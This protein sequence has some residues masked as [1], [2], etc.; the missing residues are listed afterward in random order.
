MAAHDAESAPWSH[1]APA[2]VLLGA[3][4]A[5]VVVDRYWPQTYYRWFLLAGAMLAVHYVSEQR[6]A[7]ARFFRRWRADIAVK[8]RWPAGL[9]RPGWA[10]LAAVSALSGAWHHRTWHMTATDDLARLAASSRGP[11]PVLVAGLADSGVSTVRAEPFPGQ[12]SATAT[13]PLRKRF[14]M[15]VGWLSR[16]GRWLR[17]SGTVW[18]HVKGD[19]PAVRPGDEMFVWGNLTPYRSAMNPGEFDFQ[20]LHRTFGRY[21]Y[22][23]VPVA[24]CLRV[25]PR[26]ISWRSWLRRLQT[27]WEGVLR[28]EL[29]GEA[30]PLAAA[31]LLGLRDG[32]SGR[33]RDDFLMT[34]TSHVLAIS[35]LHVG[36]LAAPWLYAARARLLHGRGALASVIIIVAVY[37]ALAEGRAPVVRASVLVQVLCC[38]WL[39]RRRSSLTNSLGLAGL[40]VLAVRPAELFGAGTQLSFLAVATLGRFHGR[41]RSRDVDPLEQLV[42]RT[43]PWWQ[44]A[45]A[46]Q[47]ERITQLLRASLAVWLVTAPLTIQAFHILSPLAI[48]LNLLLFPPL[49]VALQSGFALLLF[50]DLCPLLAPLL[51]TICQ[52]ALSAMLLCVRAAAACPG[53]H[54]WL[55]DPGIPA[56]IGAYLCIGLTWIARPARRLHCLG[57]GLAMGC[58][59]LG[60]SHKAWVRHQSLDR[61]R[62]TMLSVGHGN[63][64]VLQWPGGPV[65]LY[66]A[67]CRGAISFG[68][69]RVARYLWS[70]GIGRIDTI[71]LSHSDLDHY[72]LM[73][74]IIE[75]FG[76]RRFYVGPHR[77]SADDPAEAW[78]VGEIKRRGLIP[79]MLCSGD[80]LDVGARGRMVVLHPDPQLQWTN[81]NAR[82]LVLSVYYD[83][84][85]ILLPG[86]LEA[87]GLDALLSRPPPPQ[88]HVAMAPHHGS[89]ESEPERFLRWCRPRWC[90]ISD[91]DASRLGS[92]IRF[93]AK[94]GTL[95]LHTAVH[96]AV[97]VELGRGTAHLRTFVPGRRSREGR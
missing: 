25:R 82:S 39:T 5:G 1:R 26:S 42:R 92:W 68:V 95:P 69:D 44:R 89:L 56:V 91:S 28:R 78:L 18:I 67:G 75:R 43:R 48:P 23:D 73:P 41:R 8:R 57:Y 29:S 19:C 12:W 32:F 79:K 10:L 40:I 33:V 3:A 27:H 88:I 84:A 21:V 6:P 76:V 36:I 47:C 53:S 45:A 65:W 59:V 24:D 90:V 87:D 80:Q 85:G 13:A 83:G 22:L 20:A 94:S 81:D 77:L 62:C 71:I 31:L 64:V 15:R 2:A 7:A 38:S 72:S 58:L 16:N 55:V 51:A 37:A 61:L 11:L 86:D 52:A 54:F 50:G 14:R 66:D 97:Q 93:A 96:G 35:G 34:G 49:A 9:A 63:C 60:W 17:V 70:Q 4:C 46:R 74:G 30:A